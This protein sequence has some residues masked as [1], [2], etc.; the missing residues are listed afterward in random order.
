MPA[1]G[2]F[3][4]PLTLTLSPHAGRGD[5][6]VCSFSLRPVYGKKVPDRANKGQFEAKN[7]FHLQ[8]IL[9]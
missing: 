3:V 4:M 8:S 9:S 1:D 2:N 7:F 6:G 5:D